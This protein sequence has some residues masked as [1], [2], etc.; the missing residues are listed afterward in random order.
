[1]KKI[2]LAVNLSIALCAFFACNNNAKTESGAHMHEDGS[3]HADHDST[4]SKQEEFIVP[5]STHK[6]STG[7]E[8][9][10]KDGKEHSH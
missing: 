3:T 6:D 7:K 2:F 10:H 8:H 9:T 4:K 1:M 5:D